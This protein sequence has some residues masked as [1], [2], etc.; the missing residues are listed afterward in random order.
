MRPDSYPYPVEIS[1]PTLS[2]ESAV[3]LCE[4]LQEFVL[5]VESHYSGQIHRFY[6]QRSRDNIL[7][8][9][10]DPKPASDDPPF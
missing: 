10:A 3:E 5:L 2:D 4:F 9:D 7:Q 6:Q 8:P 1:L